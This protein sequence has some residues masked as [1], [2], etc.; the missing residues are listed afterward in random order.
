MPK[1]AEITSEDEYWAWH[2]V[3]VK[4]EQI[5][6]EDERLLACKLSPSMAIYS[7]AHLAAAT[8]AR[9][10]LLPAIRR[11]QETRTDPDD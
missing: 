8:K 6:V 5:T 4:L 11:W 1:R 2:E 3:L 10:S 9:D 7:R